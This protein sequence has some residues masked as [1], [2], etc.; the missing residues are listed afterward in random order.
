MNLPKNIEETHNKVTY[1]RCPY[2]FEMWQ[3]LG[4]IIKCKRCE[5]ISFRQL[6]R[7]VEITD[8]SEDDEKENL[9]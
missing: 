4:R 3:H 2:C 9:I 6:V 5:H 8:F 7:F 1:S